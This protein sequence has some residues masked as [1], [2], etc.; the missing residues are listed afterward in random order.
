MAMLSCLSCIFTREEEIFSPTLSSL[1]FDFMMI[2][3]KI[4]IIII[5]IRHKVSRKMLLLSIKKQ[6]YIL[7]VVNQQII[8]H[9]SS[10]KISFDLSDDFCFFE[11]FVIL[12]QK[13]LKSPKITFILNFLFF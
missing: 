4:N 13:S 3:L 8:I 7:I 5:K 10:L 1:L 6:F 12:S 2:L 11:P 9:L